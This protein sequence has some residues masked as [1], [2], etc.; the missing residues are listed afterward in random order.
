MEIVI[1]EQNNITLLTKYVVIPFTITDIRFIRGTVVVKNKDDE[2]EWSDSIT[3]ESI[4][5]RV[6]Y[7]IQH[8]NQSPVVLGPYDFILTDTLGNEK[9][10]KINVHHMMDHENIEF[11]HKDLSDI[12]LIKQHL[13]RVESSV[14]A[15]IRN[16]GA[17]AKETSSTMV[18][19][20][21]QSYS[22]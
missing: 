14:H 20:P 4:A 10:F 17:E 11:F 16:L 15:L 22:M 18:I 12:E 19:S 6:K 7:S 2:V 21:T 1:S 3:S 5:V 13:S 9:T 8:E